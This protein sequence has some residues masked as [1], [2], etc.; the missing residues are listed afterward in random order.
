MS[1]F[2]LGVI[3]RN[4]WLRCQHWTYRLGIV[5]LDNAVDGI[6]NNAVGGVLDNA[7]GGILDNADGGVLDNAV[8][9]VLD[10]AVGGILDNADGGVLDNADGGFLDNA[11]GGFLDNAVG[12]VLDNAVGGILDNADGGVLDNAVGGVGVNSRKQLSNLDGVEGSPFS[13]IV[14][15]DPH[16]QPM[17]HCRVGTQPTDKDRA[18][19]TCLSGGYVPA[20]LGLV[21][22][23]N[24]GGIFEQVARLR[25]RQGRFQLDAYGLA[26]PDKDRDAH[27]GGDDLDGG[28]EDF[29]GLYDHFP[30]LLGAS[31]V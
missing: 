7:V 29:V 13:Q 16:R 2:W 5:A 28:V 30:F 12:G 1:L 23:K 24:P 8:G 14:R 17:R 19:A 4:F 22:N 21:D 20:I 9:G 3:S 6:L 31:I 10:N 18:I 15:N 27:A 25:N 11:V 26:V